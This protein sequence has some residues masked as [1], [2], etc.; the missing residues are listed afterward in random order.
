[1]CL[2]LYLSSTCIPTTT[3]PHWWSSAKVSASACCQQ[4]AC[5]A[6]Y[7]K[8]NLTVITWKRQCAASLRK[9]RL[10]KHIQQKYKEWDVTDELN[11]WKVSC[12]RFDYMKIPEN[13]TELKEELVKLLKLLRTAKGENACEVIVQVII[14]NWYCYIKHYMCCNRWLANCIWCECRVNYSIWK[15]IWTLILWHFSM[16]GINKH[17]G[18][19]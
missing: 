6:Y 4:A 10:Q 17:Q 9:L 18:W 13:C 14:W 1:M 8:T 2:C 7:G 11:H 15:S 5:M 12:L 16:M 19:K 3:L